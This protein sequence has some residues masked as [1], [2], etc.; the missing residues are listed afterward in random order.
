ATNEPPDPKS[1]MWSFVAYY[2]RFCRNATM[3]VAPRA[4]APPAAVTAQERSRLKR[5]VLLPHEGTAKRG[6]GPARFTGPG[7]SSP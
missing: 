2:L 6:R 3:P 5:M 1:S 7:R 4:A